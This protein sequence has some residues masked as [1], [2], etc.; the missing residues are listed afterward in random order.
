MAKLAKLKKMRS[1]AE[2]EGLMSKFFA[3]EYILPRLG[4]HKGRVISF[5]PQRPPRKRKIECDDQVKEMRQ[6]MFNMTRNANKRIKQRDAAIQKQV[7]CIGTQQKTIEDMKWKLL[8]QVKKL[9]AK[10]DRINHST[11]YWKKRLQD[12]SISSDAKKK[13]LSDKI[14]SL[15]EVASLAFHNSELNDTIPSILSSEPQIATFENCKYTDDVRA[16]VYELLSLKYLMNP[17]LIA[18]CRAL[19][20][21][22]KIVT[23]L[24]WRRLEESSISVLEMGYTY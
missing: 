12:I 4:Y 7:D 5:S 14:V 1:S 22:D 3:E 20:L 2:K 10:L 6:K 9:R 13:E 11:V 24:L 16:C 8:G 17:M 18:A 19:G 21:I 23:G 15:K